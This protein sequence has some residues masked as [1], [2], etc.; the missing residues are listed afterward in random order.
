[1]CWAGRSTKHMCSR[2][3][4]FGRKGKKRWRKPKVQRI[5]SHYHKK[6]SF[7][8]AKA[9][10]NGLSCFALYSAV[11]RIQTRSAFYLSLLVYAS[12]PHCL[13]LTDKHTHTHNERGKNKHRAIYEVDGAHVY[14]CIKPFASYFR[15]FLHLLWKSFALT[16]ATIGWLACSSSLASASF[17]LHSNTSFIPSSSH[18]QPMRVCV[19]PALR[20]RHRIHLQNT[21]IFQIKLHTFLTDQ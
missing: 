17:Y 1:M 11:R 12:A 7:I 4:W 14:E 16:G 20:M 9:N 3:L 13:S 6:A 8:L 5:R 2:W 15:I 19:L 18:A 21:K 10:L